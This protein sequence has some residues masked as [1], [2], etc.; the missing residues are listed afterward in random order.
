MKRLHLALLAL[1][2]LFPAPAGAA[3]WQL[4][5]DHSNFYFEVKHIYSTIRGRFTDFSGDVVFDPA[6]PEKSRFNFDVRI[7]SVNTLIGKRDTH[8]RSSD[9]FDEAKY[10]LMRFRSSAVTP[11]GNNVYKV[12]GTLTIKDVSKKVSLDFRYHGQKDHP[13]MKK[14]V[15]G[16]DA[17]L[18]LNRLQYRVGDGK[19]YKMG[20]VDKDVAILVSL[21]LLRDR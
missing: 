4:D 13:G 12:D 20:I 21:E 9:F 6:H 2:F 18:S 5:P 7:K 16:M 1:L 17:A 19:F 10:P 3:Q 11:L 8:L 14:T 15:A